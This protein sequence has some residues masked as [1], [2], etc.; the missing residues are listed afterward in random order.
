MKFYK[1]RFAEVEQWIGDSI[2]DVV[3]R[4]EYDDPSLFVIEVYVTHANEEEKVQYFE[5]EDIPFLELI[6]I[7]KNSEFMFEISD[8][9]ISEYIDYISSKISTTAADISYN[10]FK[11]ELIDIAREDLTDEVLLQYKK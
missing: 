5:E 4:G 11:D 2:T 6:P 10:I 1:K 7:R 8:A 9:S 3:V